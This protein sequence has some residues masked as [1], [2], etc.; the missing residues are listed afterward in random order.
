MNDKRIRQI[1]R[2]ELT[3]SDVNNIVQSKLSSHLNSNELKKKIREITADVISTTFKVL[4][5]RDNFWKSSVK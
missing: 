3:K 4:W 2:E 5:Q 1:I